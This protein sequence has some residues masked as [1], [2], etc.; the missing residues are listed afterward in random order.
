[1]SKRQYI[2]ETR[3]SETEDAPAGPWHSD[4][5]SGRP[6]EIDG[7]KVDSIDEGEEIIKNLRAV[8]PDW[9]ADYRCRPL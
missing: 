5:L 4:G 1:M 2:I 8:G 9:N 3:T 7:I 6:C